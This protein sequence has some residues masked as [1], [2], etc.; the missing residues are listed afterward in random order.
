[1]DVSEKNENSFIYSLFGRSVRAYILEDNSLKDKNKVKSTLI[2]FVFSKITSS[3]KK[4]QAEIRQTNSIS[5][6]EKINYF[7]PKKVLDTVEGNNIS[8][9]HSIYRLRGD[10]PFLKDEN[11]GITINFD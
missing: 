11:I 5:R 3:D 8:N 2:R 6:I 10:L 4:F 9:F 1:M 7:S